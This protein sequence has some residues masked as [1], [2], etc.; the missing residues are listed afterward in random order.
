MLGIHPLAVHDVAGPQ[1]IEKGIL[2][3]IGPLLHEI[4]VLLPI[5]AGQIMSPALKPQLSIFTE[6]NG[7]IGSVDLFPPPPDAFP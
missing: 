4:I 6:G 3:D 1:N 7:G 5:A 2:V